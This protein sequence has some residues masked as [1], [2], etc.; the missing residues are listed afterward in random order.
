MSK[1]KSGS[2]A[3]VRLVSFCLLICLSIVAIGALFLSGID[4]KTGG[5]SLWAELVTNVAYLV[6]VLAPLG[7]LFGIFVL[8]S[9]LRWLMFLDV[10]LVMNRYRERGKFH[11]AILFNENGVIAQW[12]NGKIK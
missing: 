11:P 3:R 9:F 2:Q 5:G 10:Q 12:L 7:A 4:K 6:D 8:F 1:N